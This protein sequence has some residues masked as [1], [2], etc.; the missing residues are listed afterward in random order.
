MQEKV[1]ELFINSKNAVAVMDVYQFKG[2]AGSAFHGI[3]IA[4]GGAETAV[5]A[6]RDK[7]EITA[8]WAAKHS[9]AKGRIAAVNHL[10]DIFHLSQSG[11]K[12]ILNFLIMVS[13][14]FL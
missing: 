12:G 3:F 5:A 14:D 7:F 13:K 4:A 1:P 11:M 9:A 10:I 2:H 8:V 6:E